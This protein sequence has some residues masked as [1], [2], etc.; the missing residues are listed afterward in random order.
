MVNAFI[1]SVGATAGTLIGLLPN[2]PGFPTIPWAAGML[3]WFNYGEYW[4]PFSYLLI[5]ITTIIG[6]WMAWYVI[7]IPLRWFKVAKGD[8]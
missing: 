6:L 2:M 7:S 1:A 4:F 8:Q 3:T 5:V